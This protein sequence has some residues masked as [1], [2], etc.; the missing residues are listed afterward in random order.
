MRPEDALDVLVPILD[1]LEALH[2]AGV[3]HRD[4]K[5]SNIFLSLDGSSRVVP[6]LLDLGVSKP[7]DPHEAMTDTGMMLGTPH[8]M[9]PEHATG[10]VEVGIAA[11]IWAMG[12]VLF[13]TLSGERPFT[14]ATIPGLLHKIATERPPRSSERIPGLPSAIASTIDRALAY[15]PA[16]RHASAAEL[17]DALV[18]G[19]IE[20]GWMLTCRMPSGPRISLA[21]FTAGGARGAIPGGDD[22]SIAEAR[23]DSDPSGRPVTPFDPTEAAPSGTPRTPDR[24]DAAGTPPSSSRAGADEVTPVTPPPHEGADAS[25][26]RR[27]RRAG[28]LV[29]VLSAL[30]LLAAAGAGASIAS[31]ARVSEARPEEPGDRALV[32]LPR[33]ASPLDAGALPPA[34]PSEARATR[35]TDAGS[36]ATASSSGERPRARRRAPLPPAPAAPSDARRAEP[37]RLEVGTNGSPIIAN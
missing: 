16:S 29:L 24:R 33:T 25:R 1:A 4:L 14:A 17:A 20:A 2:S 36:L 22:P 19:A 34:R 27:D 6:K 3:V 8:Y 28:R 30:G 5:P 23:A 21:P 37:P 13:E 7:L 31:P 15:E 11:D 18:E 26:E 9:S 35:G 12:V 32:E 10:A